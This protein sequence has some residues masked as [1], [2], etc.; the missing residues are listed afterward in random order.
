MSEDTLHA[1]LHLLALM[2]KSRT[3]TNA[4]VE[5]NMIVSF[6]QKQFSEENTE[7]YFQIYEGFFS[8]NQ[9]S[10][11]DESSSTNDLNEQT[12]NLSESIAKALTIRQ[13]IYL[14][15]SLL[16]FMY[17]LKNFFDSDEALEKYLQQLKLIS[18]GFKVSDKIFNNCRFF[19]DNK[20]HLLEDKTQLLV[21]SGQE[22]SY[23]SGIKNYIHKNLNGQIFVLKFDT[24]FS[25]IKYIGS[26]SLFMDKRILKTDTT[27]FFSALSVITGKEIS[28]IY[29][30]DINKQFISNINKVVFQAVGVEYLFKG[31]KNGVRNFNI[32]V[33]SNEMIGIIGGSGAGKTTLLNLLNG[34]IRPQKGNIYINGTDMSG[35]DKYSGVL[36][37][38]IPQNELLIEELTVYE[39]LYFNA[40]LS[41]GKLGPEK[42]DEK[43]KEVLEAYSISEIKDLKVGSIV[44]KTISGGQ[45]KR[46]NIALELI[47]EPQIV[48]VDEPTSGLS[49][50]DSQRIV[51]LLKQQALKNKILFVNIHQPSDELF[52]L[53]DQVI[54]LDQGGY[55][56]FTGKPGDAL[57]YFKSTLNQAETLSVH[58]YRSEPEEILNLIEDTFV[59]D[60]G[61]KSNKR[62]VQ[63][64]Q[65]QKLFV[66]SKE[67]PVIGEV[68]KQE[69]Q[70][71]ESYLP[72]PLKQFKVYFLRNL[73]AKWSDIQYRVLALAISPT[74]SFILSLLCKQMQIT[75][76]GKMTYMFVE[77]DNIPSFYFMSVIVAMFVG[78][79]IS[80]E[81]LYRDKKLFIRERFLNL[82]INS[83][84]FS[85][86]IF[87]LGLSVYQTLA[88]VFVAQL[89]LNL[90]CNLFYFWFT[91]FSLSLLANTIGLIISGMLN[92]LVAIYIVIPLI[93][94]PQILLSGVVVNYD[95]I[96]PSLSLQE[97]V[98]VIGD[99]MPTRWAYEA[100]VVNQFINNDYQQGLI[101]IEKE[102]S[103]TAF[104]LFIQ[105]PQLINIVED[106]KLN[107]NEK[108]S[109][110]DINNIDLIK[111][112]LT[113]L[114]ALAEY[115]YLKEVNPHDF[116]VVTKD[117][118]ITYLTKLKKALN[119]KYNK[120]IDE[121]D[122]I[123]IDLQKTNG[124]ADAYRQLKK[125]NYNNSVAELVLNSNRLEPLVRVK[126]DLIQLNEPIYHL[127]SNRFGRSHFY[128][129]EKQ[130]GSLVIKTLFFNNL[131]L[132]LMFFL[133]VLFLIFKHK[134]FVKIK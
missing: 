30:N 108:I 66:Q 50:S 80:A 39:N 67:Y 114:S 82:N 29:Y 118:I 128:A 107:N 68:Q 10:P 4:V 90:S 43:I 23:L 117:K 132:W 97:F 63:P 19:V 53:F 134:A 129:S 47:R 26:D 106:I 94:V 111:N 87:L 112:E 104:P 113:K 103:I 59:D 99:L 95:K 40:H 83:Y 76:T 60:F 20:I 100:I 64:E 77:N 93:L 79:I 34:S 1:L 18:N 37:G 81:E 17:Y 115:P 119:G 101:D 121:Y 27:F 52:Y 22:L 51:S 49:S 74:L 11:I 28:P 6:L 42:I 45:R 35:S 124:G 73:K 62:I 61:N 84:F 58:H 31:G 120:L 105:I 78:L 85:K 96:H 133:L 123:I 8:E 21:I 125:N 69:F 3:N 24:D 116:N 41:I 5:K 109:K 33:E 75:A 98:P 65:W 56:I 7:K 32:Q 71:A 92:S 9:V 54:I 12:K 48:F 86:I 14:L 44:K 88:Y 13:R 16:E 131:V 25:I 70:E 89:M 130:I 38:Y 72:G 122:L 110:E 46:L 15:V 2:A 126:N 36:I 102:K 127:S 55:Q 57:G 91:M